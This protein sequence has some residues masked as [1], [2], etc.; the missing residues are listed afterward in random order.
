MAPGVRY[1]SERTAHLAPRSISTERERLK[2]L[3]ECFGATPLTRISSDAVRD[4]IGY[5]KQSGA[6]NRTI[7]ME[8]GV[9]RRILKRAK[10]WHFLADDVPHLPERDDVGRALL[11]E[12][13][14][15]L[16]ADSCVQT[17]MAERPPCYA[18]GPQH[19]D[20]QLRTERIAL[21]VCRFH[22][23]NTNSATRH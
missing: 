3:R 6:A 1:L 21:A 23:T 9:L 11:H 7:N 13:K 18:V 22:G 14:A 16:L 10:R 19:N 5:R 4:Y 20:A 15:R 2:P 8:V 17:G 12:E